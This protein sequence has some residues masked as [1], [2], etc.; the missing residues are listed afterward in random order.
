MKRPFL[1]ATLGTIAF[2]PAVFADDLQAILSGATLS[3]GNAEININADGT[4]DGGPVS[5]TWEIADGQ[6][7]RTLTAPAQAAGSE[8]QT[9]VVNGN[10]LTFTSPTGRTVEWTKL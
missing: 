8:C 10:T 5:G 1:L 9:V 2:A 7:C 6:F 4:L 3:N